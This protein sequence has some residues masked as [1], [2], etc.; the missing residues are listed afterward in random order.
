MTQKTLIEF[1]CYFP[2]KI[3]GNNS[4]TFLEEVRQ[5]TGTHFPNFKQDTLTYKISKD[6]NY[7]AITVTVFAENQRMLDA[8][9]RAI[10]E[11]PEIKMVL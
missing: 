5:I 8:F 6:A 7:I 4:S 11:H 10:T 3:I 1:P 9:Y 2:I